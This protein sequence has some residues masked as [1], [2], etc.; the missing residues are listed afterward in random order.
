M[1]VRVC[2]LRIVTSH[3]G[4]VRFVRACTC[5]LPLL[6]AAAAATAVR[7][8]NVRTRIMCARAVYKTHTKHTKTH[9]HTHAYILHMI[10]AAL[11]SLIHHNKHKNTT[12]PWDRTITTNI[13]FLISLYELNKCA[14]ILMIGFKKIVLYL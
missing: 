9:T 11:S 12:K 13:L 14:P 5:S 4:G 10:R 1:C 2:V 3:L 6:P 7:Q 8:V